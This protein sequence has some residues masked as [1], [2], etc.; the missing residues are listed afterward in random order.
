MQLANIQMNLQ[1]AFNN[2]FK[3][4][5]FGYP[6]WKSKK[7]SHQSY[8][9]NCQANNIKLKDGYICLPKI[10]WVRIKLHRQIP[11]T[12]KIKSV[13]ISRNPSG[14]YYA[15]IL[16]EYEYETP[17]PKLNPANSIGLDYSSYNFY[18]DSQGVNANYPK[19]YREI[20]NKLAKE[21]RKL[22]RMV[23][24]SHNHDK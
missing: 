4:P 11:D 12:Y 1:K 23:K 7:N 14:K 5:K 17:Q 10:K 6:K 18:T 15:S 20:E 19:Y 3:S 21:Q 24:G 22:S 2:F 16:T 8:T 9:T 13:T